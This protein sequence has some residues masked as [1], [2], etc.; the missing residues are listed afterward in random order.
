LPALATEQTNAD[1]LQSEAV[2]GL[3][4]ENGQT[5]CDVLAFKSSTDVKELVDLILSTYGVENMDADAQRALIAQ[6]MAE[7]AATYCPEQS[8]RVTAD[9]S[10]N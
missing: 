10:G 2:D 8:D 9:L 5:A 4:I 1:E 7:S 6:F 3:V